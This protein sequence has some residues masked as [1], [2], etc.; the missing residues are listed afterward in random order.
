MILPGSNAFRSVAVVSGN[1]NAGKTFVSI[2]LARSATGLDAHV[3]LIDADL[4]RPSIH[5]RLGLPRTPG[6][7]EV[8]EGADV[9]ST[10]QH[11]GSDPRFRV[12]SSGRHLT[13]PAGA[14]GGHAFKTLVDTLAEPRCFVVVDTPPSGLFADALTVA[15]QC[16]ATVFVLDVKTS[17]RRSTRR[18]IELFQRSGANVLG[19]VVNRVSARQSEYYEYGRG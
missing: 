13:D 14:L 6:L 11:A 18:A 8:L 5:E 3:I 10:L 7:T 9:H 1:P 15:S 2:N 19:I 16:D 17:R 12:L 4:R